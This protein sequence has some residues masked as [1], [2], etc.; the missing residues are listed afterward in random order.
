MLCVRRSI[1]VVQKV[2]CC[3]FDAAK[4][5]EISDISYYICFVKKIIILKIKS[6]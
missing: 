3:I 2:N 4:K 6:I 5:K 1:D